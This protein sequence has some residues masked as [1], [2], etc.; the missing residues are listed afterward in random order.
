MWQ[1]GIIISDSGSYIG[2]WDILLDDC[3]AF[4]MTSCQPFSCVP[5]CADQYI[6]VD[7]ADIGQYT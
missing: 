5:T 2:S 7:W 1:Y 6:I 3:V 4:F